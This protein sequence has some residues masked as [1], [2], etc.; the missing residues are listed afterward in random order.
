MNDELTK[1]SVFSLH[2]KNLPQQYQTQFVISRVASMSSPQ[3]FGKLLS[4]YVPVRSPR[5]ELGSWPRPQPLLLSFHRPYLGKTWSQPLCEW[6]QISALSLH[7]PRSRKIQYLAYL[8][9]QN[10]A[11]WGR[12]RGRGTRRGRGRG[13]AA[14][15]PTGTPAP[16]CGMGCHARSGLLTADTQRPGRGF[17]HSSHARKWNCSP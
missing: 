16:G 12:W 13:A 11:L 14:C 15:W 8:R 5:A 2:A 3:G 4:N 10:L 17:H 9:D 6:K 1:G 7:R